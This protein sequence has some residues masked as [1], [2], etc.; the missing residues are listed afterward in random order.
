MERHTAYIGIGSNIG[1]RFSHLQEALHSL[2]AVEEITIA[3]ASRV[4]E[5][6]PV[7]EEDQNRFYNGVILINTTLAAEELRLK[8]KTIEHELGRP[9]T[10]RR[11]SPRVIDL[12]LLLYDNC[13]ISTKTLSIPHAE[14]HRRKFVLVPLL[15]TGNP[16]HPVL[17]KSARELLASC[18]DPSVPIRIQQQ[19][20]TTK[21]RP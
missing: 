18:P 11:W 1:D 19:L 8:C 14:L 12:D 17:K 13:I 16:L 5:T 10:Y 15:D 7:G 4:Y 6:E 2:S 9:E 20:N 21:G 3:A